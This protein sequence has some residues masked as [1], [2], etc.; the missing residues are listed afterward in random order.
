MS[1]EAWNNKEQNIEPMRLVFTLLIIALL[2]SPGFIILFIP[3]QR[4]NAVLLLLL[5]GAFAISVFLVA[6]LLRNRV[7]SHQDQWFGSSMR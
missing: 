6:R 1:E 7:D 5:A 2:V 4:L 3:D